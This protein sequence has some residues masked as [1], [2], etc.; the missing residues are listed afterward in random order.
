VVKMNAIQA[1][2]ALINLEIFDISSLKFHV[3]SAVEALCL[4]VRQLE[5]SDN[6]V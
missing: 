4:L 3:V 2:R 5:E 1:L 6:K